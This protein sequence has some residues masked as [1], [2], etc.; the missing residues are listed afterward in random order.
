MKKIV[1]LL[2]LVFL[3]I[4]ANAFSAGDLAV[5]GKLGIGEDPSG[6]NYK[7]NISSPDGTSGADINIIN[8]AR[9]MDVGMVQNDGAWSVTGIDFSLNRGGSNNLTGDTVSFTSTVAL[10]DT[11]SRTISGLIAPVVNK[12]LYNS[13]VAGTSVITSSV[14]TNNNSKFARH[15][16]NVRNYT[17]NTIASNYLAGGHTE[18]G[19]AGA[20]TYS[21]LRN[22]WVQNS[23]F[24]QSSAAKLTGLWVDK[25]SSN[26]GT[27]RGIVLAG[28]GAGADIVFGPSQETRIYSSGGRLYAQDSAFNKTILSPHDPETGEW[29]YYSKNLKTGKV[30]QVN[31]EKLVKAVERLTGEKFMIESMEEMK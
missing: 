5:N 4:G 25:L 21:D 11:G 6:T 2:A 17:V 20:V 15:A 18:S 9:A 16:N 28:D 3:L 30:V 13:S 26:G 31:M 10:G 29:V 19:T 23:S 1:L 8:G 27:S 7:L 12:F 14:F 24:T 22:I